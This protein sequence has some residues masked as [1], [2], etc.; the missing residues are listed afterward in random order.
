M[1]NPNEKIPYLKITL[2]NFN[3]NHKYRF[4][5][6]DQPTNRLLADLGFVIKDES[7]YL[8][9][10][11]D[12]QYKI[13]G[14][15]NNSQE[16]EVEGG[17]DK[18]LHFSLHHSGVVNLQAGDQNIR[19]RD[20]N[21]GDLFGRVVTIGINNPTGLKLIS[22][23]EINNMPAKYTMLPVGGLI[24]IKPIFFSIYRVPINENWEMPH[25]SDTV[26]TCFEARIREKVVKYEFITWQNS[27]VAQWAGDVSLQMG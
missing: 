18:D 25:L 21:E 6:L 22:N 5:I 2:N 7:I 13:V 19:M 9:P 4:F 24:Q 12:Y 3:P 20:A 27:E 1:D 17:P 16:F 15:N 14:R 8:A 10:K 11:L 26:Q 23:D